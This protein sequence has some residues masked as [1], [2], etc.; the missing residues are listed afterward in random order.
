MATV[1]VVLGARNF[2]IMDKTE[3]ATQI[4]VTSGIDTTAYITW[5]K[6]DKIAVHS[7][8]KGKNAAIYQDCVIAIQTVT[9]S[10]GHA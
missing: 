10:R 4:R 6:G 2:S 5:V 9:E 3:I 1:H 7:P 8:D